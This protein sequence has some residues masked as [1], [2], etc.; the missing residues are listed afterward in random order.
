M[1]TSFAW[2]E[3][4]DFFRWRFLKDNI[5]LGNPSTIAEL[6]VDI[7]EKTQVITQEE[8]AYVINNFTRHIHQCLQLYGGHLERVLRGSSSHFQ[9]ISEIK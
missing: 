9:F 1:G 5:Y 2:P 7:T 6:K 8:C 4:P 3:T